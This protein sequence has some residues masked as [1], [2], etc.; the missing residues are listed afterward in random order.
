LL[1]FDYHTTAYNRKDYQKMLN[2]RLK[3]TYEKNSKNIYQLL[4]NKQENA[5]RNAKKLLES[6]ANHNPAKDNPCTTV[7]KLVEELNKYLRK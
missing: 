5:I 2:K 3:V 1:H 4:K 7:Y 6:Y